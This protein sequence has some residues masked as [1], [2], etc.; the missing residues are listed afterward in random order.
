MV[1]MRD[2]LEC[3]VH[4]GHQTRRWNPKMKKFIFGERKGIYVIDLQKTLRYFR[5]TYNIVRDAAAEGKTILF[6]GTKKQAGGAIKEY[7]EK[8]GMPYVNHRWLGGMMTNFGTIRQSIRKLEVIEKMEE[9]GSIKLLTKK[10]ALMLTRK[11]EK[12]LAYL[13][14]IRYMKTQPDMIFVID[15]V[16]E[17]IAVQEAN[18]LR[19]PVVAPLDTNCDPDLVTYP[20]P[21]NDDAIRSVQLFCQEMAE[22]IN[23]GKALREQDGEAL[24]NEEKEITDEEKKE[25][26]DE[27]M[28]EEDF[29]EEQE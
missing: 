5:Y 13:G 26:L 16:K 24:S 25:V 19:I 20:I 7:A 12:L 18:R 17:K 2:L 28:S 15:T 6:V 1:S 8:C 10:E 27:V 11:K 29:G 23:E 3:G 9:D 22:A 21:G 14:G 4:F